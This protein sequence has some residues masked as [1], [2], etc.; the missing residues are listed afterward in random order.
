MRMKII[1]SVT[2]LVFCFA[3]NCFAQKPTA[4]APAN[5]TNSQYDLSIRILPDLRRI[6]ISGTW[7]LPAIAT[8]RT[9][10]E[11]YLS[12]KMEN[13]Q[14]EIVQ[15]QTSAPLTLES[16][17]EESGDTK[18]IFKPSRPVAS[19]QSILLRFSYNSENNAAPQLN[20][21]PEGS[22]AGGGGELWYPQASFKEKDTGTLRFIVPAGEVA[23]SNGAGISSAAQKA[24]GEF[25]FRNDKPV[26][27]G[28]AAG[29]YQ[30]FQRAGK[31]RLT[32]YLLKPREHSKQ[33][34][35]GCAKALDFLTR[36]FG[37]FPYQE[38]SLVEVDFR[39]RL[40][41]TSEFGFILGDKTEFDVYNLSY[42]AHEIG[43]QWW[44]NI[45]R[46][47]SGEF[48]QMMFSEGI[49]QFGA[50]KG[51]EFIE[52]AKAAEDFRRFSYRG[53]RRFQSAAG[54]FELASSGTDFPLTLYKPKDQ[55]EIL[56]MHRLANSKGFILL[57]TLSRRIGLENF[58]AILKRFIRRKSEQLSSWQELQQTIEAEAGQDIRWFFEQWFERTGAPDYRLEWNR[59]ER[60]V[61]VTITQPEPYYRAIL[62]VELKGIKR[63]LIKTV[64]IIGGKVEFN[65]K[66]PFQIKEVNLDPH[67]KVLRW[68]PEFRKLSPASE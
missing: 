68:T 22:F 66:V 6:E 53:F 34:A 56:L 4:D 8:E 64:E 5:N 59:E 46:S 37:D 2:A 57:D 1:A 54:Y 12:P 24:R 50:L 65:W 21:S 60:S 16:S 3:I 47:R 35:D 55:K 27:F 9:Q 7:R 26:K 10:I 61:K 45:V 23:I 15:P 40:G 33:L 18:W 51:V 19:G 52:G 44:G 49:T 25:T 28:F 17:K 41:G 39:S 67:Y 63:S 48:G 43:H 62:E 32:L 20:I 30:V 42:W 13:F 38:F 31:T 36:L 29:K 58:A 11:F 14:L